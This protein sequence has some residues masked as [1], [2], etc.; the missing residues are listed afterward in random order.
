MSSLIF[1]SDTGA[2]EGNLLSAHKA[3]DEEAWFYHVTENRFYPDGIEAAESWLDPRMAPSRHILRTRYFQAI[4][5]KRGIGRVLAVGMTA[6]N[7][8]STVLDSHDFTPI[9]LRGDLDFSSRRTGHVESFTAINTNA[10]RIFFEDSYEMDK[11]AAHGSTTPHLKY[12]SFADVQ[13]GILHHDVNHKKVALVYDAAANDARTVSQLNDYEEILTQAGFASKRVDIGSLYSSIDLR[14]GRTFPATM[15][16]RIGDCSHCIIIGDSRNTGTV[17]A[18]LAGQSDRIFVDDTFNSSFVY[19]ASD[20]ANFGRGLALVQKLIVASVGEGTKES[21]L[22]DNLISSAFALGAIDQLVAQQ[23]PWFYEPL[24]G[25][26]NASDFDVFFTVAPIE[27]RANGARPQ[28]IR[29]IAEAFA[30]ERPT[31]MVSSNIAGLKRKTTY[32]QWLIGRGIRPAYF[33]GENSTTPIATY[34]GI[35]LLADLLVSLRSAGCLVGWFIR[36]LHWLDPDNA[37]LSTS[38]T[39]HRT[40]TARG[41]YEVRVLSEVCDLFFAPNSESAVAF[42]GY[43]GSHN[44]INVEWAPLPPGI[45]WSNTLPVKSSGLSGESTD[46]TTF[47]YSGGVGDV[48]NMDTY[49]EAISQLNP[50]QYYFDFVVRKEEQDAL[51]TSIGQL[52]SVT[53]EAIRVLNVDLADYIPRSDRCVGIVLI[54]STYANFSFPYKTMTM[55]ERGYPILTFA[56]MAIAEFVVSESV[57]VTCGRSAQSVAES[58]QDLATSDYSTYRFSDCRLS[59][60]WGD[61]ANQ[62]RF[63]L[64]GQRAR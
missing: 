15:R 38:S 17:I 60:S 23:L 28:R 31:V 36:D 61:R 62:I 35:E 55:I 44:P 57:G 30:E 37:Y 41:L 45:S 18:G 40:I 19:S 58:M 50:D 12:P 51:T 49:L 3:A 29:N 34:D 24:A 9:L 52:S 26:E 64:D 14:M 20:F 25:S 21:N 59:N 47:V 39:D 53:R 56:D 6:A 13:T 46:R 33:Y 8:A 1:I 7:Y 11:A 63:S 4:I 2:V 27:N 43:L 42:K 10:R 48:Y 54:S 16:Y 22:A 5:R 32:L